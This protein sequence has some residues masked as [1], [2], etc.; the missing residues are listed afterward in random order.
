VFGLGVLVGLF[1][2]HPAAFAVAGLGALAFLICQAMILYKAR[3]IPN[4]RAPLIPWMIVASGLLEGAGLIC[5]VGAVTIWTMVSMESGNLHLLAAAVGGIQWVAALGIVLALV[6]GVLWHLYRTTAMRRGIPPL[7]RN[8][9]HGISTPLHL[10]GH[11][12]VIGGFVL[13]LFAP[14]LVGMFIGGLAA[15]F[16]GFLWKFTVIVRASYQQGFAMPM[17][18][19]RGSGSRAAPP[20]L[21][22]FASRPAEMQQAAE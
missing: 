22:G 15:I 13:G 3:G 2:R 7:S 9:L 5:L 19:A 18:P 16:G 11:A 6:N 14:L 8:V 17:V 12:I 10:I 20:R 1:T 4:W 21:D